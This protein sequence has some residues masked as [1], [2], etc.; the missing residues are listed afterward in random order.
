MPIKKTKLSVDELLVEGKH[1][2]NTEIEAVRSIIKSV[3][4]S[5]VEQW[6]WNAPSYSY[7]GVDFVTFNLRPQDHI[8][9]V[10]HNPVIEEVKSKLLV[11]NYVNRRMLYLKNIDEVQS[12]KSELKRIVNQIITTLKDMA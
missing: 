6:K 4:G 10:F 9:L 12:N 5:I 11:G 7:N 8:H 2:L 3:D 1:P